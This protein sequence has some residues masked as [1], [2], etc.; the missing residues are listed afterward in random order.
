VQQQGGF[1]RDPA[2]EE[3]VQGVGMR[4]AAS[5]T[6]PTSTTVPGAELL[7]PQR[8]RLPAE[9][10]VINRGLLVG[11]SSEAEMAAVL[12]HETGHVT[13]KHSLA[14]YQRAIAST[15]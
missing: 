13:A 8:L 3:Y 14:G 11:L 9:F 2:L 10:I 6:A 4:L 7:R 5:P 1:Y 12:G 15:S